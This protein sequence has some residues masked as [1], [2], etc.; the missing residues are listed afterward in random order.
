MAVKT[1]AQPA[2]H[3]IYSLLSFGNKV[4]VKLNLKY[5]RSMEEY[6]LA[7]RVKGKKT[8]GHKMGRQNTGWLEP[9]SRGR[10]M[11]S[12]VHQW[13]TDDERKSMQVVIS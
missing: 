1:E 5:K 13:A 11:T 4:P 7:G 6:A 3:L 12:T 8:R 9:P 2:C 10:D